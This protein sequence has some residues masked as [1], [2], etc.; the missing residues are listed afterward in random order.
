VEIG[1]FD[2]EH[3]VRGVVAAY[4][5]LAQKKGLSFSFEVAEDACGRYLG[6]SAR[7]RRIL[8]S[9]AD[10]AVKFTDAGGVMLGVRREDEA[11][12]FRVDDSGI[13]IGDE[14]LTHLFEASSRRR[15]AQPPPRRRGPG[16]GGLPRDEP[17]DGGS[18]EAI[19]EFG[20]GSTFVVPPAA[21]ARASCEPGAGPRAGRR[22]G[23]R[24]ELR[25]LA[26]EDNDTNQLVLKTLLA[27]CGVEITLVDD[28]KKALEAWETQTWDI[29]LMDI[30]MP[31][32]DGVVATRAIRER[33][34]ETGGRGRRSWRSPPTP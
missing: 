15:L 34:R 23:P 6:D 25:V 33:E 11:L 5:P 9:L 26:A 12:V 14:H 19:S 10:N 7:I 17:A 3:L 27:Q 4:E 32:M 13:G 24:G 29:I 2:L 28:G 16:P 22:R 30:Q 31:V 20:A 8:Y 1:D 18:I 21:C